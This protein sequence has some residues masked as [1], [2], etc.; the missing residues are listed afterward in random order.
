[1]SNNIVKRYIRKDKNRKERKKIDL[2]F[3]NSFVVDVDKWKK[4]LPFDRQKMN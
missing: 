1:M 3:Q 2:D 4:K